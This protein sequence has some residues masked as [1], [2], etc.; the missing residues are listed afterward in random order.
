MAMIITPIL[1]A[2]QSDTLDTEFV[3][4]P[5]VVSVA[6][7]PDRFIT[8]RANYFSG[9]GLASVDIGFIRNLDA[10][11]MRAISISAG[12]G[13]RNTLNESGIV[14]GIGFQWA[15]TG[16][17]FHNLRA[18][19]FSLWGANGGNIGYLLEVNIEFRYPIFSNAL[20][21]LTIGMNYA[22]EGS[23]SPSMG[24]SAGMGFLWNMH[25]AGR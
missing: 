1:F 20:L 5:I 14:L 17:L 8:F 25:S 6:P 7:R 12:Y 22:G 19:A 18:G 2:A 24:P 3:V 11:G 13:T 15:R 21:S 16:P 9:V 10:R 23:D 4:A